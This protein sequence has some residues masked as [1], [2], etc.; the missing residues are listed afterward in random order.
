MPP[1]V[2]KEIWGPINH[3]A[4]SKDLAMQ[5]VQKYLALGLTPIVN[6]AENIAKKKE[7]IL[8][9]FKAEI[10]DAISLIGHAFFIISSKRRT[11]IKSFLNDRY[12]KICSGDIPITSFLFGDNCISKLKEMGDINR[13]PIAKFFGN[14]NNTNFSSGNL[15]ARGS[16]FRRGG[17]GYRGQFSRGRFRQGNRGRRPTRSLMSM[18]GTRGKFQGQGQNQRY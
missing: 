11:S 2:N 18:P 15:N 12:A 5:E 16:A 9:T 3:F 14:R 13:F 6:M 8:S 1:K 17:Q 10:A 4:H 7:V